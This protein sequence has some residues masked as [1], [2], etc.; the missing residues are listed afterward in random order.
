MLERIRSVASKAA[1]AVPVAALLTLLAMQ[2]SA[3]PVES[4]VW[5][6]SDGGNGH[7]YSFVPLNHGV[8]WS[9]ANTAAQEMTLPD[10]SVGYLATITSPEEWR[11]IQTEVL[12]QKHGGH[13]EKAVWI[14]DE[15]DDFLVVRGHGHKGSHGFKHHGWHRFWKPELSPEGWRYASWQNEHEA[16]HRTPIFKRFLTQWIRNHGHG[17]GDDCNDGHPGFGDPRIIG[18]IVEFDPR[19]VPEPAAVL[20]SALGIALL[21]LS[22]RR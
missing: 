6:V 13:S 16:G 2:S 14:G 8:S 1:L 18:M 22:R 17:W 19:E 15:E 9:D 5:E 4:V 20:L 10:G 11:F 12:P 21:G 7:T 3:M